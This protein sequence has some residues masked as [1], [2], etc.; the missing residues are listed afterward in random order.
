[1][2][3]ALLQFGVQYFSTSS[4]NA[5]NDIVRACLFALS[6]PSSTLMK[7]AIRGWF[8]RLRGPFEGPSP[9][10]HTT[11]KPLL[12]GDVV[13]VPTFGT[14]KQISSS[15]FKLSWDVIVA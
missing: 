13:T 5:R 3:N 9:T 10:V 12:D 1:V 11:K 15:I 7:K 4:M 8:E 2:T 6:A 14:P